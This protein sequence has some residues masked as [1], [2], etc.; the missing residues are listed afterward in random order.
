[1]SVRVAKSLSLLILSAAVSSCGGSGGG[2]VP[3]TPAVGSVPQVVTTTSTLPPSTTAGGAAPIQITEYTLGYIR[4]DGGLAISGDGAVWTMAANAGP[5][6]VRFSKGGVATYAVSPPA[7]L[8][9]YIYDYQPQQMAATS[10]YIFGETGWNSST[11]T[12]GGEMIFGVPALGGATFNVGYTSVIGS[13]LGYRVTSANNGT[14]WQ[15]SYYFNRGLTP[16]CVGYI[17]SY[18]PGGALGAN[19]TEN[20]SPSALAQGPGGNM[21]LGGELIATD[22]VPTG[23]NAFIVYS[24][25]GFAPQTFPV[26]NT[27]T[28]AVA[29]PD[30][31]LWFTVSSTNQI[32]RI[33][34]GGSAMYYK[35][36]TTTSLG[37]IT[38]GSDGALW[39]VETSASKIGRITTSGQISEYVI[40]TPN[41]QPAQI[42]GP[43][44]GCAA[45]TLWFAEA[46]SGKLAMVQYQ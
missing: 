29:G 21:W 19:V 40:P 45:Y 17:E 12:F 2:T 4:S 15:A 32:G 28:G 24:L 11:G 34:T 42:V 31:A 5:E 26:T 38:V 3:T 6:F 14:V 43:G 1:M 18:S 36:P 23:A 25:S 9:A 16:C 13:T 27:P 20:V 46:G 33:T 41:S 39:F 35:V 44:T 37:D 7:S 22:G 10:S 8:S 30:G